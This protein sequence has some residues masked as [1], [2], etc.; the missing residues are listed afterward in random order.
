MCAFAGM[1]RAG[2]Y[3]WNTIARCSTDGRLLVLRVNIAEAS[4][5]KV[6]LKCPSVQSCEALW[7]QI[8]EQQAFFTLKTHAD[9][10]KLK[11]TKSPF[12][13]ASVFRFRG[14]CQSEMF[15]AL[16]STPVTRSGSESLSSIGHQSLASFVKD[17]TAPH[18]NSG[19]HSIA[20]HP[21]DHLETAATQCEGKT[22]AGRGVAQQTI[23][24]AANVTA[25]ESATPNVLDSPEVA[26]VSWHEGGSVS[27]KSSANIGALPYSEDVMA[28]P[29]DAYCYKSSAP[30]QNTET[31]KNKL[32]E[33]GEACERSSCSAA[34]SDPSLPANVVVPLKRGNFSSPIGISRQSSSRASS[35]RTAS[36]TSAAYSQQ[37]DWSRRSPFNLHVRVSDSDDVL[38]L[39]KRTTEVQQQP[40]L[41]EACPEAPQSRPSRRWR[42]P[43]PAIAYIGFS[44]ALAAISFYVVM[45]SS[46]DSK[47]LM[48]IRYNPIVQ[49]FTDKYY[50]PAKGLLK[51]LYYSI[52]S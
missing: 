12:R 46:A 50:E 43:I 39:P 51:N 38:R 30:G 11:S 8:V 10:P 22:D 16:N 17:S 2:T 31:A 52:Q 1:H 37:Q 9:A 4:K 21:D 15:I 45:E 28:A 26:S 44:I 3:A 18:L 25:A 41:H 29:V 42:Q 40:Q 48:A 7:R 49:H 35:S 33:K 6:R 20:Q 19:N 47:L 5:Q 27:N 24:A 14:R 23:T 34:Q 13:R 32:N 36:Q